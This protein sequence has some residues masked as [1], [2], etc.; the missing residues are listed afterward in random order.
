MEPILANLEEE[1]KAAIEDL[2][3]GTTNGTDHE[4]E[5]NCKY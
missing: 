1:C 2:S 5:H 4:K 3:I